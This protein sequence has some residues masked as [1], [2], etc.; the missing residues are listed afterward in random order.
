MP[1]VQPGARL[2]FAVAYTAVDENRE[3]WDNN[4]GAN[5]SLVVGEKHG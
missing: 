2:E 4:G 5:Y 1:S 3:Y